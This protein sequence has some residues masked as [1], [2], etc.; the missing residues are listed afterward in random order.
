MARLGHRRQAMAQ[1]PVDLRLA[2]EEEPGVLL[3][4]R[5]EA[6]IGTFAL[7]NGPARARPRR[8]SSDA[9]D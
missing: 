1:Q 8:G 6:A 2:T 9:G 7:E 4:E 5:L 3:L